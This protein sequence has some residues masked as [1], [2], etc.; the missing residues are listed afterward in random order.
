[1]IPTRFVIVNENTGEVVNVVTVEDG[2]NFPGNNEMFWQE[3][4]TAQIGD[5]VPNEHKQQRQY[6]AERF[7]IQ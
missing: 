4:R 5:I 2:S 1:M 7:R 6:N 3:N